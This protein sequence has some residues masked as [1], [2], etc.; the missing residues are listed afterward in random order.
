MLT[1]YEWLYQLLTGLINVNRLLGIKNNG[2]WSLVIVHFLDYLI[3]Y[4]DTG[5][6][7]R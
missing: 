5:Y 2:I 1:Q 7:T 6:K 4:L 3:F